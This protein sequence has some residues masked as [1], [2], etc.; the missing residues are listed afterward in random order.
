M[1]ERSEGVNELHDA[2][3]RGIAPPGQEGWREAPGWLFKRMLLNNH[4]VC[5]GLEAARHSFDRAATPPVQEG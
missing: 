2:W 3:K 5:T 4:P 1:W